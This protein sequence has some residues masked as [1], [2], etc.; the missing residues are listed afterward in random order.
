LLFDLV[1]IATVGADM[2][3]TR[4]RPPKTQ[5]F[6][7]CQSLWTRIEYLRVRLARPNGRP[8]SISFV[9]TALGKS[10]GVAEIVG[11]DQ[12]FLAREVGL[13]PN[14]GLTHSTIRT[15]KGRHAIPVFAS[16]VTS[17]ATRI[18]NLYYEANRWTDDPEI[19]FA[20]RNMVR[21]L[22]GQPR[23]VRDSAIQLHRIDGP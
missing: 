14:V 4:G 12:E 8:A 20:W 1:E 10:G 13:L 18:R 16:Y 7:F 17:N 23:K 11:G 19:E 5:S 6:E 3:R 22:C 9:A 2:A 15:N 21:D